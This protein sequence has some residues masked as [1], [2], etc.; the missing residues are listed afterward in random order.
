MITTKLMHEADRDSFEGACMY[1]TFSGQE[2]L[3]ALSDD[4]AVITID[5]DEYSV[6]MMAPTPMV[7]KTYEVRIEFGCPDHKG[8]VI[9]YPKH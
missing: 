3:D 6:S 8:Y 4:G 9:F 2:I 7:G 5:G 1:G